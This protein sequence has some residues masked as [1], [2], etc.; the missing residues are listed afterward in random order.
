MFQLV[1]QV[2]LLQSHVL[3]QHTALKPADLLLSWGNP[4]LEC[5][6]NC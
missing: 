3:G 1:L 5:N 6:I 2:Q 4:R